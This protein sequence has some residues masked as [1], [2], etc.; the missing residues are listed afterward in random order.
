MKGADNTWDFYRWT[1][2]SMTKGNHRYERSIFDVKKKKKKFFT[3]KLNGGGYFVSG[4]NVCAVRI[5][6]HSAGIVEWTNRGSD[7][8]GPKEKNNENE[9][10]LMSEYCRYLP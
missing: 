1:R 4:I 8:L 5:V 2:F 3:S 9:Q 6:R 7:K 10:L